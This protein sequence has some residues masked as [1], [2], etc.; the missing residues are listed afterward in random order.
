MVA[1]LGVAPPAPMEVFLLR[2]VGDVRRLALA[3]GGVPRWA[4]GIAETGRGRILLANVDENGARQ[5]LAAVLAHEYSHLALAH[6]TSGRDLP[7]WFVEGYARMLAHE[8]S[9][10]RTGA[11]ASLAFGGQAIRLSDLADRFPSAPGQVAVAYAESADFVNYLLAEH[12]RQRF[13]DLL[14]G[15]R[16]G[17]PF[18][19][20]V[21]SA[22]ERG[23]RTLEA[24][25]YRRLRLRYFWVPL[26]SS[27]SLLWLA[28]ASLLVLG[29]RRQR[30]R[31]AE[32]LGRWEQEE[33]QARERER[34]RRE[35]E[36]ER[37]GG[38]DSQGEGEQAR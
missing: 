7:L 31:A 6:A 5:D 27:G 37:E 23:I 17:L 26:L 18:E 25:W 14:R 20:A 13:R 34:L 24:D 28:G 9:L 10:S 36:R 21:L 32:R 8:W 11:L 22:Y 1:D 12:G 30:R 4:V 16:E 19:R 38:E 35:R 29:Y 15:L 3:G 33:E 2:H